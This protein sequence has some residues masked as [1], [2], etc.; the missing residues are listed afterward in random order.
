MNHNDESESD[1]DDNEKQEPED[2]EISRN[3]EVDENK[4]VHKDIEN[5]Y[6]HLMATTETIKT[7]N[8]EEAVCQ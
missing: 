5:K 2:E 8:Q 7:M 6:L 3:Q 4:D 1:E